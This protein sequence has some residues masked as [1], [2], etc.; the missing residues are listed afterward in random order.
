MIP[1]ART[2]HQFGVWSG[3][4][5]IWAT[6][7][8]A[9]DP[10]PD[11]SQA[12]LWRD[13]PGVVRR[14]EAARAAAGSSATVLAGGGMGRAGVRSDARISRLRRRWDLHVNSL[15][16][17]PHQFYLHFSPSRPALSLAPPSL[18]RFLAMGLGATFKLT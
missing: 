16:P 6:D 10:L 2:Q 13:P 5:V 15:F 12:W 7:R 14:M 4:A 8:W 11:A 3:H 17:M 18:K 9:M 1:A